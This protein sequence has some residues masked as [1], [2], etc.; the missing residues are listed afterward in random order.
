MRKKR[1]DLAGPTSHVRLS[2]EL[3]ANLKAAESITGNTMADIMRRCV[4]SY[5]LVV[6]EEILRERM[7]ELGDLKNK[8]EKGGEKKEK[9]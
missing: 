1:E 8:S 9:S 7:A 6:T 2:E 3:Y 5:L 4:D